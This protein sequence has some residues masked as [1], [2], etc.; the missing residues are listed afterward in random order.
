MIGKTISHYKIIEKLGEGGM[1]VVY[2]AQDTKLD[3]IVALKFLPSNLIIN[4]ADKARFIQEAKAAAA[5]NHPNVCTIHEIN[6]E[7]ENPFIVMEYVEGKTLSDHLREVQNL[8]EVAVSYAIQIAKALQEAHDKGIIHRD[9]KSENIMLTSTDQ[10]KVMDFGLAKLRGSARLTTTTGTAGTLAYSSPEQV[11][12][13]EVDARSD[14]FSFGVVLYEMLTGQLPFKGEYDSAVVYSILDE[15]PDP[16]QQHCPGIS[17]ELLHV[18]NRTLEKDPENRYQSMKD[19]LIDLKRVQ[20]DSDKTQQIPYLRPAKE[21]TT[22]IKVWEQ[23]RKRLLPMIVVYAL[24]VSAIVYFVITKRQTYVKARIPVIVV[25]FD[26]ET[27]ET[28]LNS[29]AGM[30][31]TAM[32]PSRHLTVHT[33][34]RMLDVLKRIGK[35]EVNQ[36]DESLGKQICGIESVHVMLIPSIQKLGQMYVIDLKGVNP[37]KNEFLFAFKD[38]GDGQESIYGMIDNLARQVR[39]ALKEK[40]IEIQN[41]NQT[42]VE[43][44][45][46][47][48]EAYEHYFKGESYINELKFTEAQDE[49]KKAIALDSTFGMAYYR[50]AYAISWM[51]GVE[52]LT[53][54]PIRKAIALIDQIPAK[55][56]YLV[57]AEEA[58]LKTGFG[59]GVAVLKEMEKVY[60]NDKEM[61]Y[62]IGDWSYH[63]GQYDESIKY[64][65]KVLSV[66]STHIRTLQ[67]LCWI[68]RDMGQ[69]GELLKYAKKYI[70]HSSSS[71]SYSLLAVA[72]VGLGDFEEA[73]R[74]LQSG[75]EIVPDPE[76]ISREIINIYAEREEYDKAEIEANKLIQ[77]NRPVEIKQIGYDNLIRFYPY[78]GKYKKT[79]SLIDQRIEYYW[80]TNDTSMA[81][82]YKTA[83]GMLI[84]QGWNDREGAWKE[85]KDTFPYQ[86]QI[87]YGNYWAT[88]SLLSVIY[89][90][91]MLAEKTA[92]LMPA[93]W[94]HLTVRSLIRFAKNECPHVDAHADSVLQISSGFARILLLYYRAECL[95]KNG[96]Y[97]QAI[98]S[99]H[100]LHTIS[101]NAFGLR[102]IYYP[103]SYY[104]LGKNYEAKG[105]RE[106]AVNNYQ[107][108][109]SLWQD[110][111]EDLPNL[112]DAKKRLSDLLKE[113]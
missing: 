2:K 71:E 31:I 74:I 70:K 54:V 32:E 28:E 36:I 97:D 35:K 10:I 14:I 66:D 100:R 99:L 4:A 52:Q 67:H 102:A 12:G 42:L 77:E 49:F 51:M 96:E 104:Q 26:N 1:G 84:M 109:L 105:D 108:F 69:F 16:I 24:M 39:H 15:E 103:I 111:D 80:Q 11:Q 107:R 18:L 53:S 81:A 8:P 56:R 29:L 88:L 113:G 78:I 64:L 57:R 41:F 79:L 91:Y 101:D 95:Y 61:I 19:V 33:R 47:N 3:R 20:R 5:L 38:K 75:L 45:T 94:W 17:S 48:L 50:L 37:E 76:N 6:D 58:Q 87:R 59:A 25:D 82:N 46:P 7:S 27:D 83:K 73:L 86:S 55:E 92:K 13:K 106:Q 21:K 93:T 63:I 62:N 9:I 44:T 23:T 112:I 89:G 34:S 43:V 22:V 60:P 68:Y 40:D 90:D 85:V 72:Y 98:E 110:A 65:N 30:F